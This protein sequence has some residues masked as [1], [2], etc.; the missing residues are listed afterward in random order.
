[1]KPTVSLFLVGILF[2]LLPQMSNGQASGFMG[3]RIIVHTDLLTPALQ[4]G[5]MLGVEAVIMRRYSML[6]SYQLTNAKHNTELGFHN[7]LNEKI[8][9]QE[10]QSTLVV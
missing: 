3:K 1:M 5:G 8:Q 6:L 9:P 7:P 4:R 2:L 10:V